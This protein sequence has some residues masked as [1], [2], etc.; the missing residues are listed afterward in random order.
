M[1]DTF[2]HDTSG[3]AASAN[4]VRGCSGSIKGPRGSHYIIGPLQKACG[5]RKK[6][7]TAMSHF[8]DTHRRK[9][10]AAQLFL[11]NGSQNQVGSSISTART[12]KGLLR[13]K[14]WCYVGLQVLNGTRCAT[15]L[16]YGDSISLLTML[17]QGCTCQDGQNCARVKMCVEFQ[18]AGQQIFKLSQGRDPIG[19][20]N[21]HLRNVARKGPRSHATST[22]AP[23]SCTNLGFEA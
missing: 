13:L 2:P 3:C 21:G 14:K 20:G 1:N 18:S 6:E 10:I 7:N 4:N 5:P 9:A 11:V 17:L 22:N 19:C 15:W 23:Q 8:C 12:K 16:E